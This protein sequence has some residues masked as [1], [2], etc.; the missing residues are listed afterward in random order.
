[1][2]PVILPQATTAG[3]PD[4]HPLIYL[5]RP[6]ALYTVTGEIPEKQPLLLIT[7]IL[8]MES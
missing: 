4:G 6:A 2:V 8:I 5:A 3:G 1:M 7:P